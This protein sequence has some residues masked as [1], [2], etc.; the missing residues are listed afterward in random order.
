MQI[1]IFILYCYSYNKICLEENL[2]DHRILWEINFARLLSNFLLWEQ[3]VNN[4]FSVIVHL[5]LRP[6][7]VGE[8]HFFFFSIWRIKLIDT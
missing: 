4:K 5:V 7:L 6:L 1:K 2:S 8:T 3:F